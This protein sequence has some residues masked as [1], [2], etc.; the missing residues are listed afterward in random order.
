MRQA[1][2]KNSRYF[3]TAELM[4]EALLSLLSDR[5]FE[6]VTVKE[7]CARAG[8]SR[9]TFYLH[10]ESMDELLRESLRLTIDR[11]LARFERKSGTSFVDR[12]RSCPD[13]EL[14]LVTSEFLIPYLEFVRDNRRLFTALLRNTESF[15]VDETYMALERHVIAP[16][17]D[18]FGVPESMRPYLMAFYLSGLM[19]IVGEWIRSGCRDAP[20]RVA[21]IMERCCRRPAPCR[22]GLGGFSPVSLS[23]RSPA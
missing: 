18:R 1:M 4:D 6:F 12:L 21:V 3:E 11:F 9:S 15:R 2:G 13:D 10:Y 22:P 8:V 17:L 5:D 7:V 19:A 23:P 16:V 14:Y 20:E